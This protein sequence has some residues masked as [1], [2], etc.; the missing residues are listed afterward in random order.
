MSLILEIL[1]KVLVIP[2]IFVTVE[3]QRIEALPSFSSTIPGALSVKAG[4]VYL[5]LF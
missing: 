4:A 2:R 3:S 5:P 1:F